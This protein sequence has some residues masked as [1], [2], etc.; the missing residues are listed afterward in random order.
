M[1]PIAPL[2]KT[3]SPLATGLLCILLSAC[4]TTPTTEVSAEVAAAEAAYAA[5]KQIIQA[6][7]PLPNDRDGDLVLDKNDICPDTIGK[8]LLTNGCGLGQKIPLQNAHFYPDSILLSESIKAQLYELH[9]LLKKGCDCIIEIQGHADNKEAPE[10]SEE[11]A[12]LRAESA[13][14]FL[15]RLGI[16]PEKL[17]PEGYGDV[18][19]VAVN[20]T[21]EGRKKNRRIELRVMH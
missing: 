18:L 5:K 15:Q 20:S 16:S 10:R 14:R 21:P 19:A 11:L 4:T 2:F 7:T 8:A 3:L 9:T 6:N 1:N 17:Y 12:R 13:A